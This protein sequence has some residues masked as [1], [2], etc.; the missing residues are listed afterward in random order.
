VSRSTT[1]EGE[2]IAGWTGCACPGSGRDDHAAWSGTSTDSPLRTVSAS[3]VS[4]RTRRLS[5]GIQPGPAVG[6]SRRTPVRRLAKAAATATTT[7]MAAS[8]ADVRQYRSA[9]T[10]S[11]SRSRRCRLNRC[12]P[13]CHSS[14]GS[15]A[16]NARRYLRTRVDLTRRYGS[17]RCTGWPTGWSAAFWT[18]AGRLTRPGQAASSRAS[19]SPSTGRDSVGRRC[20]SGLCGSCRCSGI[21]R[22]PGS[23]SR[24]C[25]GS[26][27]SGPTRRNGCRP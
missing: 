12:S 9:A 23:C 25:R 21:P 22:W 13:G 4:V 2:A 10:R 15:V 19:G 14:W 24:S 26:S 27:R 8:A 20:C 5:S 11:T 17:R 3:L 16:T 1:P 7:V 6:E 18:E